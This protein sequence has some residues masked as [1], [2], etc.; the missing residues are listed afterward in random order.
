MKRGA[1]NG[2]SWECWARFVISSVGLLSPEHIDWERCTY[3]CQGGHHLGLQEDINGACTAA[4]VFQLGRV[5]P[6]FGIAH[7]LLRTQCKPPSIHFLGLEALVSAYS[8]LAAFVDIVQQAPSWESCW[9]DVYSKYVFFY[10][11]GWGEKNCVAGTWDERRG[12]C[13][14]KEAHDWTR[15]QQI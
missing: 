4:A 11:Q 14:R 10:R 9:T 7:V 5:K 3:R 6:R 8:T 1:W 13:I 15:Q 12:K 2:T